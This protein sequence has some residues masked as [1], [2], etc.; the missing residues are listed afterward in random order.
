MKAILVKDNGEKLEFTSFLLSGMQGHECVK[1]LNVDC[2]VSDCMAISV[3]THQSVETLDKL[4]LE[5]IGL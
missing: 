4:I 2:K 3:A 5:Q 1:A